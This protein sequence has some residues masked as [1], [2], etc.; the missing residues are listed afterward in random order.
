MEAFQARVVDEK[1]ELDEKL[2]R[3]NQFLETDIFNNLDPSEQER[4]KKQ[5]GLMTGYSE[6]LGERIAAF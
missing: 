5:Q 1:Q 4:L 6:V 3:L 2:T